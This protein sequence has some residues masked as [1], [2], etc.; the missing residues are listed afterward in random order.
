MVKKLLQEKEQVIP[1]FAGIMSAQI[2]PDGDVWPCCI[3]ADSM[4]KLRD[5]NYNF[6][7]LWKGAQ[8][9]TVRKLIKTQTCTCPLANA[10]YTNMLASPKMLMKVMKNLVLT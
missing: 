8:A 5:Y 2:S 7:R 6:K 4:G 10:S 1:C 3:R 9:H